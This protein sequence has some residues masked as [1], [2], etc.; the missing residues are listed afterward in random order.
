MDLG[1]AGALYVKAGR[2]KVT[3]SPARPAGS[4]GAPQTTQ[5]QGEYSTGPGANL[6]STTG[7]PRHPGPTSWQQVETENGKLSHDRHPPAASAVSGSSDS[8]S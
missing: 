3:V 7:V 6:M 4:A 8:E 1:E 5:E 2:V